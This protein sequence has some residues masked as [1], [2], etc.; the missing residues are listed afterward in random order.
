MMMTIMMLP[1]RLLGVVCWSISFVFFVILVTDASTTHSR[2]FQQSTPMFQPLLSSSSSSLSLSLPLSLSLIPKRRRRKTT[3]TTTTQTQTTSHTILTTTTFRKILLLSAT[4]SLLL[5]KKGWHCQTRILPHESSGT[6]GV[7]TP[8]FQELLSDSPLSAT[9]SRRT[10]STALRYRGGS[11]STATT[12]L[13]KGEVV[14]AL[15]DD[16]LHMVY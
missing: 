4:S 1:Q 11:S 8:F 5:N 16:V 3:T 15:V 13:A 10:I 7:V 9:S 14:S 12:V 6:S 2:S